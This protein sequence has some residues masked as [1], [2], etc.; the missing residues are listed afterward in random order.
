MKKENTKTAIIKTFKKL[1]ETKT[2]GKITVTEISEVLH[3]NRQTFYYHFEDVFQL[4]KQVFH[5][6]AIIIFSSLDS[7]S[8]WRDGIDNLFDYIIK[9]KKMCFHSVESLGNEWFYMLLDRKSVV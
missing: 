2:I 8:T 5:D 7:N 6:E 9:N 1:L 3:I 4:V